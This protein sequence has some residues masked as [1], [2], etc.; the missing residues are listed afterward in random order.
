MLTNSL[1]HELGLVDGNRVDVVDI[2]YQ[3][4]ASASRTAQTSMSTYECIAVTIAGYT[5]PD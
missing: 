4:Q 2:V 1:R 3:R 5:G